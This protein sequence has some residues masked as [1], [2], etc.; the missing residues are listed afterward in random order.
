MQN[1]T[2]PGTV[3]RI[4]YAPGGNRPPVAVA[5]VDRQY[6][7]SP[8]TVQFSSAL[9][10]DPENTAL[11]CLWNFGD[12]TTST[13]VNPLKTFTVTGQKRYDVLLTMTDA[14]GATASSAIVVTVNNTPPVVQITSPAPGAQY[15]LDQGPVSYNLTASVT[16]AEHLTSA[17]TNQW[18]VS[19]IHDNHEHTELAVNAT[20]TAATFNALG[21]DPDATYYYRI[22]LRVTDPLGLTTAAERLFMPRTGSAVIVINPDFF[23]VTSGGGKMLDVLANDHG[24]V[25]DADFTTIQI[26]NAPVNGTAVPDPVTGRI[27]YLH[28][29]PSTATLDTFTYRLRTKTGSLSAT[30]TASITIIAA[31]ASNAPVALSDSAIVGRGQSVNINV[32]ANDSDPGGA[33]MPESLVILTRPENGVLSI[34]AATGAVNYTHSNS[35][36]TADSFTYSVADAA[37]LRSEPARVLINVSSANGEPV[38][39]SP[40]SQ[41][42]IRGAAA[43]LQL[44]ASDP[45][46]QPLT[47]SA[48]GLPAGLSL[49]T[50]GLISGTVAATAAGTSVTVTVSDGTLTA[51]TS[52]AWTINA[53]PAGNGLLQQML[54]VR[55]A[56]AVG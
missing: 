54:D 9:S 41:T 37:G 50:S 48:T 6:G 49:N 14:G 18:T 23:T 30:G 27:R 55:P 29:T 43:S 15:P 21:N 40:G 45:N 33:L 1:G 24:A 2:R 22:T 7:S 12:G 3:R 20:T 51:F 31:A 17:L 38:I 8:L 34:D 53:P 39:F 56:T 13:A 35:A 25:T 4:S 42:S 28:N 5:G 47:W 46:G 10:S 16:D 11:T 26:V 44:S 36:L 19:L 32:L 52:F